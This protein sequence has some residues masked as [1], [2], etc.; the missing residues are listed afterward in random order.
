MTSHADGAVVYPSHPHRSASFLALAG[1]FTFA[2]IGVIEPLPSTI[3]AIMTVTVLTA[4]NG[5]DVDADGYTVSIDSR[6]AQRVGVNASISIA[7]LVRGEHVIRLDGL[8]PN[9][10]V[11]GGNVRSVD[12]VNSTPASPLSVSFSVSCVG[13][14]DGGG[15]GGRDW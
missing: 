12:V 8:S 5:I 14:G 15:T 13:Q 11:T 2:C 6:S 3:G 7:S 1:I 9:C 10:S 4:G